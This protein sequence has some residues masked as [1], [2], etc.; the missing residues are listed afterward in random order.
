MPFTG[1][2]SFQMEANKID[3]LVEAKILIM[4]DQLKRT[5]DSSEKKILKINL[6]TEFLKEMDSINYAVEAY[7]KLISENFFSEED[8]LN[9]ALS[10]IENQKVKCKK[11]EYMM[12]SVL[13]TR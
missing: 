11:I 2:C 10:C 6:K 13:N 7:E 3:N 5:R 12:N 8:Q 1:Y 9:R 4:I